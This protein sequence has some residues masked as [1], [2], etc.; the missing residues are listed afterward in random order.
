MRFG[1]EGQ[2][3]ETLERIGQIYKVSKERIRQIEKKAME[4]LRKF[5]RQGHLVECMD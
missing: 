2:A 3:A 4:K 1:L 5:N